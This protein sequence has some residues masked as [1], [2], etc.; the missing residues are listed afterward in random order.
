MQLSSKDKNIIVT[1][2]TDRSGRI[3]DY[4]ANDGYPAKEIG[5]YNLNEYYTHKD[6][7]ITDWTGK[8]GSGKTY[9][10]LECLFLLAEK[11]GHV[12]ALYVP[13]LGSY[14]DIVGKLV[15]M[16]T[17]K[18]V[19][20]KWGNRAGMKD[21]LDSIPFLSRHFIILERKNVREPVTPEDIWEFACDYKG[22]D[23]SVIN[24]LLIDSWKNLNHDFRGKAEYQYLDYILSYRNELAE[25]YN[26]HF[27]TIVHSV[28]TELEDTIDPNTGQRKRRVPTAQ[29]IKGGGSWYDNGKSIITCDRPDKSTNFLDIHVWKTKPEDV[30]KQGSILQKIELD[31]NRGRY[32]EW[33]AGQR[34]NPYE[35][36]KYSQLANPSFSVNNIKAIN[37]NSN[38]DEDSF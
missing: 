5:F 14:V 35:Y 26:K 37:P 32:F 9:F 16:Y 6:S 18:N 20:P 21:V 28:K 34:R 4:I 38:F 3:E 24:N 31:W 11:F 13:D 33:S 8:P 36:T 15:K 10:V 30:G 12:N 22:P 19:Q 2:I 17:G 27:H 7:G 23:G 29:D 25:N 1:S